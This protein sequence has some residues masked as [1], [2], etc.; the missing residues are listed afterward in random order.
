MGTKM[1]LERKF[2]RHILK[3]DDG[4]WEWTSQRNQAGYGQIREGKGAISAHR[5]AWEI[6]RGK[7]PWGMLVLHKCDRPWC[8]NPDHLYI[9]DYKDN[10][11]DMIERGRMVKAGT[12]CGPKSRVRKLTDD[13]VRAIR[14]DTR[15]YAVVAQAYGIAANTAHEIINRKR[16][17]LVPD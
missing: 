2:H 8:V 13:Q 14:A 10:T 12:Y 7:I 3:R 1:T 9:G 6:Y 5:A 16:K 15:H 17:T 4:C 11:R